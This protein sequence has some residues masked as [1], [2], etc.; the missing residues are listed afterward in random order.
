MEPQAKYLLRN[1]PLS[2]EHPKGSKRGILEICAF[3]IAALADN[4]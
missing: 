4:P 1:C 2:G 3:E